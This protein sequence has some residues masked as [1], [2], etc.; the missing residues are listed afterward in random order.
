MVRTSGTAA[1]GHSFLPG[2]WA[3]GHVAQVAMEGPAPEGHESSG[4]GPNG[5]LEA[6]V[7]ICRQ[8]MGQTLIPLTMA[9]GE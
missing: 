2:G 8:H 7:N 4:D 9:P 5:L 6:L 1:I 3:P